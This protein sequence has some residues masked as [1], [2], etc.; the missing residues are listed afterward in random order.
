ML[1][2]TA[3][4]QPT[5]QQNCRDCVEDKTGTLAANIMLASSAALGLQSRI[6]VLGR[7]EKGGCRLYK[8]LCFI[9]KRVKDRALVVDVGFLCGEA[10]FLPCIE[11]PLSRSNTFAPTLF[12][13]CN[14]GDKLSRK[15][16]TKQKELDGVQV[17]KAYVDVRSSHVV[18]CQIGTVRI[19]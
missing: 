3:D 18:N 6:A 10:L 9:L 17:V 13:V 16:Y 1:D 14:I 8:S 12:N 15:I 4:V 5:C 7:P 11:A 19:C 2:Q